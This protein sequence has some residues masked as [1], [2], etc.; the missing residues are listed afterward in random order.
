MLLEQNRIDNG[1]ILIEEI[2]K[3]SYRLTTAFWLYDIQIEGWKLFLGLPSLVKKGPTYTYTKMQH[4]I[5]GIPEGRRIP[6]SDISILRPGAPLV[7]VLK[8]IIQNTGKK[9]CA[10]RLTSNW[11]FDIFVTDL[12]LYRLWYKPK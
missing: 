4:V 9:I 6:L 3:S 2:D 1:K 7:D 11:L 8:K 5:Q 10:I 12:Y